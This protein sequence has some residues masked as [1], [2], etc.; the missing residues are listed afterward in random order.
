M[1]PP[2]RPVFRRGVLGILASTL[3]A[4]AFCSLAPGPAAAEEGMLSY[5]VGIRAIGAYAKVDDVKVSG[6]AGP[7]HIEHDTDTVAGIGG[8][9]GARFRDLPVRLELEVNHRFRF[10]FD[11][12]DNQAGNVIDHEMNLKTTS[13]LVNAALEWR[14]ETDFTPFA[15][16]SAGWARNTVETH[17]TALATQVKSERDEDKDNFA[18]GALLGVDWNF[19]ERWSAQAA[20]RYI[21]LGEVRSGAG[22][23]GESIEADDYISHDFLLGVLFRF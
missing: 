4:A 17:R 2:A 23:A 15:G 1:K 19:T 20:Y 6:F 21:D 9:V 5:Y 10:D 16:V 14:N 12:R 8:V 22:P 7:S 3:G 13:A 18:W 11:V